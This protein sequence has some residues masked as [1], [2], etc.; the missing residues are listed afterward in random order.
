[1]APTHKLNRAAVV[2]W[3]PQPP[4]HMPL[5]R[6]R[7]PL[8]P[9]VAAALWLASPVLAQA[10][11]RTS[12]PPSTPPAPGI[13]PAAA[14]VLQGRP[15]FHFETSEVLCVLHFV[16]T[17][18]G[19]EHTS[20]TYRAF[21]DS[22]TAGDAGFAALVDEFRG[23]DLE[24]SYRRPGLPRRRYRSR[25]VMDLLWIQSAAAASLED[26]SQRTVG[27]L[28]A[29]Q[30]GALLAVL[31]RAQPYYRR[32]VWRPQLA[33]IRRTER[34]LEA[35]ET[36][37]GRLFYQV[38]EFYG[39][40]WPAGLD[41]VTALVPLPISSGVATAVPK[42]NTL[43]CS[44]LARNRED[45]R[46]TLGVAV[47]EMCHSIYDEQPA[48]LQQELDD[49]FMLSQSP[50]ATHAYSYF[51]EALATAIGNGWA[52]ER[53]NGRPSEE[54]WYADE[55]IDGFARAIYPLVRAY[56]QEHARID[57][58]FVDACIE[59]FAQTFPDANRDFAVL[60]SSVGLYAD[61]E[62]D[63]LL[64]DFSEALLQRFK[65]NSSYLRAPLSNPA[66]LRTMGYPQ[67]TKVVII[68][69]ERR[70]RWTELSTRYADMSAVRM[71]RDRNFHYSFYDEESQSAVIVF[72]VEDPAAL[73]QL[74]DSLR[75]DRILR[76][77]EAVALVN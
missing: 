9:L 28:P 67:L 74:L 13:A 35:Y 6:R 14:S 66:T 38:A 44:Y 29:A 39:T 50:H 31:A 36:R 63:G 42:A 20:Q 48:A 46:A 59:A 15:D 57:R 73:A 12:P 3:G 7:A 65:V 26:F 25:S 17:A 76:F 69:R 64:T 2:L 32:L 54:A 77:G 23:V 16:H 56:L 18:A 45:Y 72:V 8:L 37:V 70:A 19:G 62:D 10:P 53:L 71:P 75:E 43:V 22:A 11:P 51:N 60:V 55:F 4:A 41:F 68:D 52:Y 58:A 1:M 24:T 33:N 27:L 21:V 40:P 47:H 30:H 5:P 34:F 49:W 61:T